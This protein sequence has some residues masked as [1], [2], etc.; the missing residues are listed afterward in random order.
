MKASIGP[1]VVLLRENNYHA[2]RGQET[3]CPV[4]PGDA[5]GESIVK[6]KILRCHWIPQGGPRFGGIVL[7]SNWVGSSYRINY[8]N[9]KL[10]VLFLSSHDDDVRS[11]ISWPEVAESQNQALG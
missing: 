5:L 11:H 4:F 1:H 7:N 3:N 2:T 10:G 8:S 9:D 6:P